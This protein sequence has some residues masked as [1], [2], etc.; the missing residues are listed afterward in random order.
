LA[1]PKITKYDFGLLLKE[2]Y[3]NS[4]NAKGRVGEG[5][6]ARLARP[7]DRKTIK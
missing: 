7:H 2:Y 3:L 4:N 6:T 1:L 5:E